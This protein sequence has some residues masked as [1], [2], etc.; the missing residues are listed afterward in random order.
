M[1]GD[2]TASLKEISRFAG[3]MAIAPELVHRETARGITEAALI[4]QRRTQRNT[5]YITGTLR[6]AWFTEKATPTNFKAMVAN[7]VEYAPKVE[8]RT[9]WSPRNLKRPPEGPQM[10]RRGIEDTAA[11]RQAALEAIPAN[12]VKALQ[13]GK[14]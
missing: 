12:I 14:G 10:L 5:P 8:E 11:D 9:W 7:T 1:A 3:L 6:R 13:A 2:I 4:L